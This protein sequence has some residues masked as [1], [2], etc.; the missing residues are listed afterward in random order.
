MTTRTT[1]ILL[2]SLTL[3]L[4]AC[5]DR[6]DNEPAPRYDLG[7]DIRPDVTPDVTPD[8]PA[9]LAPVGFTIHD[10]QDESSPEYPGRDV[11]VT[12][13]GIVTAIDTT[14]DSAGDFYVQ[15]PAGGP[16]S[17][18]FIYNEG[19]SAVNVSELQ[20]GQLVEITGTVVEYY[21]LTEVQASTM[22]ISNAVPAPL[23]PETVNAADVATDG[24]LAEAY[25]GVLVQVVD[26]AVTEVGDYGV[27][28]VTGGLLVDDTLYYYT[29]IVTPT[30]GYE[31]DRIA[32]VM[33]FSYGERKLLPRNAD[34][35]EGE[36]VVVPELTIY[37]IQDESSS[38]YPGRDVSVTFSGIVTAIDTTGSSAGDFF[39]QD[40]AGGPYSGI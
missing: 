14:G 40:P 32:G 25:E 4:F 2:C 1:G 19:G 30:V 28:T 27:F 17:G 22:S 29:D 24:S 5:G 20:V 9:D 39:V 36:E 33:D 13:S 15:D 37:D 16:Y 34:D 35:M 26:T 23:T 21:D 11:S 8:T 38:E 10:I 12:F 18:I 7:Q 6:D 3:L 31:F